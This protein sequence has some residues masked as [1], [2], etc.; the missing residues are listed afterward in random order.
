MPEIFDFVAEI[1]MP[2]LFTMSSDGYLAAELARK[3]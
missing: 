2:I 1:G 3:A